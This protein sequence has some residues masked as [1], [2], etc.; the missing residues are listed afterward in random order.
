MPPLLTASQVAEAMASCTS[1]EQ[2]AKRLGVSASTVRLTLLNA[3]IQRD[4]FTVE[5]IP[6]QHL[7][8]YQIIRAK[9]S[10]RE[11]LRIIRDHIERRG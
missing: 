4:P 8:T 9:T 1:Y 3:G 10:E 11:A 5:E 7:P 2:A 6:P